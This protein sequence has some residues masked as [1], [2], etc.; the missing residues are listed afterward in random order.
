ME[1]VIKKIAKAKELHS[2]LLSLNNEGLRT[3]PDEVFELDHLINI[4]KLVL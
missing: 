1:N 3:I 2:S 4:L